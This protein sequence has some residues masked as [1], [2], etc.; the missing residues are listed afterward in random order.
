MPGMATA[1]DVR[2]LTIELL[3]A[4]LKPNTPAKTKRLGTIASQL[5]TE[6]E[7][8]AGKDVKFGP[9]RIRVT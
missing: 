4:A 6:V 3:D 5:R 1:A 2:R 7:G 8:M 9:V